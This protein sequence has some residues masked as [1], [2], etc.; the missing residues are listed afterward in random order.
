MLVQGAAAQGLVAAALPLRCDGARLL[1][2]FFQDGR[3][4]SSGGIQEHAGAL[5]G[6][7]DVQ[8][9]AVE[10]GATHF[11]AVAVNLIWRAA[12]DRA[13]L[14]RMTRLACISTGAWVHGGNQLE[15]SWKFGTV[16]GA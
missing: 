9:D 1:A 14:P 13:V 5:A 16:C 8:I 4:F 2:A 15:P 10:E 7:L 11:A 3:A 6:N 12:T